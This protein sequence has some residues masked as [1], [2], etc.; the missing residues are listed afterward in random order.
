VKLNPLSKVH[1]V[2]CHEGTEGCSGIRLTTAL[3]GV[4]GERHRPAALSPGRKP[5]TGAYNTVV[6]VSP[7]FFP[8]EYSNTGL[9]KNTGFSILI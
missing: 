6:P 7:S 9:D 2:T 5:G 8:P 4:G 1:S 3:D